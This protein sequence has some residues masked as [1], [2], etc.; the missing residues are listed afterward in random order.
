[1]QARRAAVIGAGSAGCAAAFE[2]SRAGRDVVLFER[3]A[4]PGGR[5]TSW[6]G[7][8]APIDTGAG[9]FTNFYPRTRRYVRELGLEAE[10]MEL[11]RTNALVHRGE[12]AE[13]SLGSLRSFLALPYL[14]FGEKLRGIAYS[15]RLTLRRSRLD[16]ADPATLAPHDDTDVASEARRAM[17]ENVY[18][19]LVRPGIEPFWYFR[20]EEVSRSLLLALQAHAANARFFSLRAGTDTL[21]RHL[22]EK[23]ATRCAS[24]VLALEAAPGGGVRLR[25]RSEGSE[26]E[27]PFDEVVVATTASQADRLTSD[28]PDAF[29]S[30]SQRDFLRSQTYAPNLHVAFRIR[31]RPDERGFH[32]LMPCGPGR[33][34]VASVSFHARKRA[35]MGEPD[36]EHETLSV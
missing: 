33:A 20:C 8:G 32:S 24:E 7:A 12:I 34:P 4:A 26:R 3:E 13:L 23:L 17:G 22:A 16:L 30:A 9:F 21:C 18:Q 27:E 19:F 36:S 31:R 10:V 2:L 6:R 35:G 5:T 1:M 15:A 25:F 29:V 28:L 11:P 14:S